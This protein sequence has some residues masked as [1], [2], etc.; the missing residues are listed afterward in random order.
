MKGYH[1]LNSYVCAECTFKTV[2]LD[3][4]KRHERDIHKKHIIEISPNSK[5]HKNTDIM[6]KVENVVPME[7]DLKNTNLDAVIQEKEKEVLVIDFGKLIKDIDELKRS[8]EDN[9]NEIAVLK[10][11]IEELI[12][13]ECAKCHKNDN[14]PMELDTQEDKISVPNEAD[15]EMRV[16]DSLDGEW[17]CSDCSFQTNEEWRLKKHIRIGH[18]NGCDL[19]E[20]VFSSK[21]E[22]CEHKKGEHKDKISLCKD[23][24]FDKCL[25]EKEE[26]EFLH[27]E[28]S[29]NKCT[30]CE[31]EFDNASEL[32]EH[33][34]LHALQSTEIEKHKCNKCENEFSNINDLNEHLKL[35]SLQAENVKKHKCM[36]CYNA[37]DNA[38][39]IN[40]HMKLHADQASEE[41]K[42]KCLKCDAV[43]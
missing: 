23:Y 39:D 42:H 22:L 3:E 31:N 6:E 8:K 7:I 19:C 27:A 43:F 33:T 17:I 30:N 5:K 26:C 18:Q 20:N 12:N 11:K 29:K 28:R 14:K 16:E 41:N 32:N 13:T 4:M 36:K 25:N 35:H 1:R 9:D 15:I 10:N 24:L 34:K 2:D 38:S 21:K 37:F 40:E